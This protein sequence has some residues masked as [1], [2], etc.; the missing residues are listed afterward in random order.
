MLGNSGTGVGPHQST[1]RSP[2]LDFASLI[3]VGAAGA[4]LDLLR[5]GCAARAALVDVI[6]PLGVYEYEEAVFRRVLSIPLAGSELGPGIVARVCAE[7]QRAFVV[8]RAVDLE[9]TP[10]KER[11]LDARR[12]A[13]FE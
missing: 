7:V 2:T 10:T 13:I 3:R 9:P 12:E 1:G 11:K 4:D 6:G 8:A 5:L